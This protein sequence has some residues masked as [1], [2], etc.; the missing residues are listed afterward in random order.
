MHIRWIIGSVFGQGSAEIHRGPAVR[1]W[2]G[3]IA[4][5]CRGLH[6]S[7]VETVELPPRSSDLSLKNRLGH[8]CGKFLSRVN[9]AYVAS[10]RIGWAM[11]EILSVVTECWDVWLF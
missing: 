9:P 5:V 4:L 3:S 10:E 6:G 2:F 8:E 7:F 11:R 1:N